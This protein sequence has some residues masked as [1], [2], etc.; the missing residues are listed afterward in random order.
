[1]AITWQMS[2][3]PFRFPDSKPLVVGSFGD[4]DA[5]IKASPRSLALECDIAE[6]RLDLFHEAHSKQGSKLWR[7]LKDF[8]LLFTARCH[9]EGSPFDLDSSTRQ[10]LLMDSMADA[11]LIDIE[12]ASISEMPSLVA[13]INDRNLPW[14]ASYH[15]FERLPTDQEIEALAS[16][17]KAAGASCFKF[18]AILENI[19]E[20]P[21]LHHLQSSDYGLPIAGMGM[22]KL[23]PISRLLCA[24]SGSSLNYG[25]IGHL[26][27][28]PGQW[29]AKLLRD[30]IHA[31]NLL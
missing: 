2:K 16:L 5:I 8:P 17:A 14:I 15:N 22:G 25:Y 11:S 7:H 9:A 19:G 27:T 29:P 4:L 1:M 6:I 31:L 21:A 12:V 28:A 10:A 26:E 18:A 3:A 23:A 30:G 20:L 13:E 24:Q